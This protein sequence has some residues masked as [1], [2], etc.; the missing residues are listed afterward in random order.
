MSRVEKEERVIFNNQPHGEI[1]EHQGKEERMTVRR[2][3]VGRR[4][5]QGKEEPRGAILEARVKPQ[6]NFKAIVHTVLYRG[7]RNDT[8]RNGRRIGGKELRVEPTPWRA[9][10][11]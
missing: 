11:R 5:M 8:A 3:S 9:Q 2:V 7:I 1:R 10:R 4:G 6:P